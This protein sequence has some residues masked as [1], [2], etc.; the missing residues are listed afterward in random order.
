MQLTR[1]AVQAGTTETQEKSFAGF[2]CIFRISFLRDKNLPSS[3]W[4]DA[5]PT[6]SKHRAP[7]SADKSPASRHQLQVKSTAWGT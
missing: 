5:R 7:P 3:L 6:Q 4:I 1:Q 2:N